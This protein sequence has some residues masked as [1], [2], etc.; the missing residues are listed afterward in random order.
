MR[1]EKL[2]RVWLSRLRST[3]LY[4]SSPILPFNYQLSILLDF[5]TLALISVSNEVDSACQ[6]TQIEFL[7]AVIH[8]F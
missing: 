3:T 1:M 7:N 4:C 6:V 8:G 2:K 5:N